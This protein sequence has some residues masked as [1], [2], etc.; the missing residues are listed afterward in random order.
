MSRVPDALCEGVGLGLCKTCN[1]CVDNH[2]GVVAAKPITPN[3]DPPKCRDWQALPVR[4]IDAS[5][6]R[7]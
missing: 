5:H 1:R 6:G 7:L 4:A 2:P 3:I